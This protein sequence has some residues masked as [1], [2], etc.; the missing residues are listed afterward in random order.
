[1]ARNVLVSLMAVV[2]AIIII[3]NLWLAVLQVDGSSMSPLLQMDEIVIAVRDTRPAKNDIIAFY[4]SNKIH[5]K[6]VIATGGDQ[7]NIDE[8][9]AVTVNG[10]PLDEPYITNFSLG[11]CDIEFPFQ[12]PPETVF[13]LG[14]NRPSSQDSRDSQF[15]TV[16]KEQLIGKVKFGVWPLKKFGAVS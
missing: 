1:M 13:V 2:S 12:V 5:I 11:T 15:G 6:R 16:S 14:D 3:T 9:G 4:Y 8:A 7:V 10:R